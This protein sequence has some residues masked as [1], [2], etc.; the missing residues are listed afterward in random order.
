[1]ARPARSTAWDT[2]AFDAQVKAL[3][4]GL[5][6]FRQSTQTKILRGAVSKAMRIIV[7][8]IKGKI[9]PNFKDA[10][11]AIGGRILKRVAGSK[12]VKAKFGAAVGKKQAKAKL[13][14]QDRKHSRA[15]RPG[16]GI[17]PEN[18]HWFILGT[19]KRKREY[20]RVTG[21]RTFRQNTAEG[22][23]TGSMPPQFGDAVTQGVL[24]SLAASHRAMVD[25][26]RVGIDREAKK[27]RDKVAAAAAGAK[28]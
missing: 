15:G 26:V 21:R 13:A 9:P 27:L 12:D 4:Y 20:I 28:K 2:R 14:A 3:R 8:S 24:S 17:G 16:V 25:A 18:I 5:L 7:K 6:Q 19:A 11:K 10:K 23:S 22:F 1:M